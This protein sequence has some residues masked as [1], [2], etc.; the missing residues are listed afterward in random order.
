MNENALFEFNTKRG[1]KI[2]FKFTI[3]LK[4]TKTWMRKIYL[5]KIIFISCHVIL[6]TNKQQLL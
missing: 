6:L 4:M 2:H 3:F 5:K 1:R